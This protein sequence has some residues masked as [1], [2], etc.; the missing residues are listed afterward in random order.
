MGILWGVDPPEGDLDPEIGVLAVKPGWNVLAR[1]LGPL[2]GVL[3]HWHSGFTR[4]CHGAETC[5]FH[6]SPLR[7]RGYM[8]IQCHGYNWKGPKQGSHLAVLMVL[9]TAAKAAKTLRVGDCFTVTRASSNKRSAQVIVRS[10]QAAQAK[11]PE[12]FDVKPYVL[13]ATRDF[14][15][16]VG[17]GLTFEEPPEDRLDH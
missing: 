8:P 10:E 7:W 17:P 12:C 13:K 11:L 9:P 1:V 6:D 4:V 16:P 3:T 5:P 2:T 15:P 14:L